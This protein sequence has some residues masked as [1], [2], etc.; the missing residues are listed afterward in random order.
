MLFA[1]T[2]RPALAGSLLL[3]FAACSSGSRKD[4][5]GPQLPFFKGARFSNPANVTHRYFPLVPGTSHVFVD[6]TADG[7]ET[8]VAEVLAERRTTAS[9]PADACARIR[10]I[11]TRKTTSAM[12]GTWARKSTATSTTRAAASSA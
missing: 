6:R 2:A 10:A 3:V 7:T 9:S 11:G 5:S 12:S 1:R 4:T 8:I